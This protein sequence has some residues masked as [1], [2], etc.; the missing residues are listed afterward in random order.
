MSV[1]VQ[2][3]TTYAAFEDQ[4]DN[5]FD[6][7]VALDHRLID[8]RFALDKAADSEDLSIVH[9]HLLAAQALLNQA[10]ASFTAQEVAHG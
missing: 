1:N 7:A 4:L 5:L 9:G 8:L 6:V 10:C 2:S 3:A